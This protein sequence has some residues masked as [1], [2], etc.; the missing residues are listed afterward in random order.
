MRNL[1]GAE[2]LA[3][4]DRIEPAPPLIDRR[5]HDAPRHLDI[6]HEILGHARRHFGE[7]LDRLAVMHQMDEAAH[8]VIFGHIV[9]DRSGIEHARDAVVAA[10]PRGQ[11]RL[12]RRTRRAMFVDDPHHGG[13][14]IARPGDRGLHVHHQHRVVFRIG[15]QC[16][17]RFGVAV[18]V[19]IADQIDRV[20]SRP[21][22]RQR[23]I[24]PLHGRRG[25][26]RRNAAEFDQPI[27]REHADA[28]AIG[29]DRQPLAARR[30][31]AAERFG[32]IEQFAQVI[33]PQ[34]AG[35]PECGV[36]DRILA[37]ERTGVGGGGASALRHPPGLHH[38]HRFDARG[39]ARR[40]HEFARVGDRLDIEQDCLGLIIER[41]VIEQV[42]DVDIELLADRHQPGE[43]DRF[44]HRPIDHTGGD[45]ARL[46][47]QRQMAG[48]RHMS[49]EAG[50]ERHFRHDHTEAVRPHQT[51]AIFPRQPVGRFGVRTGAAPETGT[52]DHRAGN[53]K[54]AGF[55]D[56][57]RHGARRCRD[58]D[59][60]GN[61]AEFAQTLRGRRTTDFGITRVHHAERTGKLPRTDVVENRPSQRVGPRACPH[62]RQRLR[63]QQAAQ[64]VMR[65]R[66]SVET[67]GSDSRSS[68]QFQQQIAAEPQ[69]YYKG[70]GPSRDAF[71]RNP[72]RS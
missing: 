58:N 60:I 12:G 62:Q 14:D 67:R 21:G 13:G 57:R 44:F 70:A 30:G 29:G 38:H 19:G 27:D 7:R 65:H 42:G 36:I 1:V 43:T 4:L 24:E 72:A 56:D 51:H 20:R 55:R 64:S 71:R 5:F 53:A 66:T 25:N 10:N 2:Q 47:D 11:H 37:G 18:G 15:E 40:G 45:R 35:A 17:Q 22:G 3:D 69:P 54:L 41:E 26:R 23:G 50:I 34:H 28:A 33:D 16:F 48:A 61:K 8:G 68:L 63:R 59:E 39:G 46:R 9:R 49:G 31:D 6:G 52:D 32:A